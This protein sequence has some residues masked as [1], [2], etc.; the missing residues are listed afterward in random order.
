MQLSEILKNVE[1][2]DAI[3]ANVEIKN[4]QYETIYLI[5]N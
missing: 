3:S 5:D 4:I 2:V 1:L